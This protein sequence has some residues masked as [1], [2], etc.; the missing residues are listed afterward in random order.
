MRLP[1][2]L[3][4]PIRPRKFI[5][6]RDSDVT[7]FISASGSLPFTIRTNGVA[8]VNGGAVVSASR[9]FTSD[10]ADTLQTDGVIAGDVLLLS[11]AGGSNGRYV[12][13][14]VPTETTATVDRPFPATDADV[15][16]NIITPRNFVDVVNRLIDLGSLEVR[17]Q[18]KTLLGPILPTA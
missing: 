16:Y 15:S 7:D 2:L 13:T 6:V 17:D 18:T 1:G 10:G 8:G 9:I 12:I 5:A 11:D 14:S 4:R 3:A